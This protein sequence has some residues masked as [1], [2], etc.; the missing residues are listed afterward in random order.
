MSLVLSVETRFLDWPGCGPDHTDPTPSPIHTHNNP[1]FIIIFFLNQY[2]HIY[3]VLL[4]H[5]T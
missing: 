2:V 3:F 1:S 5:S 4:E